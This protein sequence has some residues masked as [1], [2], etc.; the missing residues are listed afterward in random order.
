MDELD[1]ISGKNKAI[2]IIATLN[3]VFLLCDDSSCTLS[4]VESLLGVLL[5]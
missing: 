1:K 3:I 5:N 4:V 2:R